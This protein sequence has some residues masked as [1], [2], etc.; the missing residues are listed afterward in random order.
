V[1]VTVAHVKGSTPRPPGTKMIVTADALHGTIGGGHLEF[2]AIDIAR[3]QL[4]GAPGAG[5]ELRRFPLGASLGQCC[6]GVVNLLFEPVAV[7]ARWVAEAVAMRNA[8][9]PFVAMVPIRGDS[10]AGRLL[11]GA[12]RIVGDTAGEAAGVVA[13]ARDALRAG[14][15]AHLASD[16][17]DGSP[18]WFVDPVRDDAFHVVLF[19]A[20][21]V[22]RALVKQLAELPC[23]VTWVDARDAEFPPAIPANVEVSISD[24]PEADVDAAPPGA[25]FLV[26][27]H[28]HAL[29]ERLAERILQR[30]D[31]AYFG[32][33]G[34]L[35][36]RRRFEQ[37]MARRGMPG[38]RFNAMT[39]PIGIAGIAGKEPAT[40]ALAV[41]AQLLQVRSA[42][43]T[44]QA[45]RTGA[46]TPGSRAACSA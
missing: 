12:D 41:A 40:I 7:P 5:P 27:T 42:R 39:C 17:A 6:G 23:R 16:D 9:I 20:G 46:G 19:G 34:S 22:G 29:D 37:R 1:L 36:K 8:R 44:A 32:L 2:T 33:I 35:S 14:D 45:D 15:G 13:L 28:D 4:D 38:D 31:F 21:H 24:A 11:V 25:Y 26:M 10:A 30:D 43:A 18:R 3:R